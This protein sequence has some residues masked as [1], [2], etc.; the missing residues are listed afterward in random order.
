MSWR[1]I[2]GFLLLGRRRRVVLFRTVGELTDANEAVETALAVV[3]AGA[4]AQGDGMQAWLIDRWTASLRTGTFPSEVGAFLPPTEAMIFQGYG[5]VDAGPLFAAAAR[6]AEMRGRQTGALVRTLAMPTALGV[7]TLAGL[8]ACGGWFM[9]TLEQVVPA[10]QWGPVGTAFHGLTSAIWD[11]DAALLAGA[12][13]LI[14]AVAVSL[15]RWTGPG[16]ATADRFLP[17]SLARLLAGTAFLLVALEHIRNG[18]DLNERAFRRLRRRSSRYASHRIAA[19]ERHMMRGTGFGGSMIEAGHGFPDP[20][21]S[22]VIRALER[23]PGWE[24]RLGDFIEGWIAQSEDRLRVRTATAS[25][26]L[27]AFAAMF[28]AALLHVMG[29]VIG[30]AQDISNVTG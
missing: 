11:H 25:L 7:G 21:L 5:E 3:A 24:N 18:L 30:A 9:P 10:S 14:T 28:A 15:V 17:W 22:H 29:Q 1:R 27:Q 6:I 20:E 13:S 26:L 4:R 19:I 16:R 2:L 8:W 23:R 12:L